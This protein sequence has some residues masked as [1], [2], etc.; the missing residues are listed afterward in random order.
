MRN[1]LVVVLSVFVASWQ[2]RLSPPKRRGHQQAKALE[3]LHG[4]PKKVQI[5]RH[6]QAENATQDA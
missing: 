3:L 5:V 1:S 6:G 2:R 4:N